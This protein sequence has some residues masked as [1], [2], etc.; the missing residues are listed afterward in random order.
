MGYQKKMNIIKIL[1]LM[2]LKVICITYFYILSKNKL[3]LH[4]REQNIFS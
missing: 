2:F 3:F 4:T 1:Q